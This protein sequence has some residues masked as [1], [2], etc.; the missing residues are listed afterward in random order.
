M[1]TAVLVAITGCSHEATALVVE[2]EHVRVER[3]GAVEPPD[4]HTDAAEPVR[5][6]DIE[7]SVTDSEV[8]RVDQ[9]R[10][11]ALEAGE[12]E[13]VGH[14]QGHEVRWRLEVDPTLT[15]R[16]VD[17]PAQIEVGASHQL[18]VVAE[19]GSDGV[20]VRGVT[21]E[22]SAPDVLKVD[23]TGELS[24]VRVGVGY[25]TAHHH[26]SRSVVEIHVVAPKA[27]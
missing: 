8:A 7:W 5:V 27:P 6:T 15:L 2:Q 14:W 20:E 9:G 13:V 16:F 12:A 19:A 18:Q 22:S 4:V 11:V 26:G 24:G 17:A 1:L 3:L 25:I 10:V 21:F 23:A